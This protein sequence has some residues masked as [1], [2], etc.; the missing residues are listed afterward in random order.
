MPLSS[1]DKMTLDADVISDLGVKKLVNCPYKV[2]VNGEIE[3][4]FYD[5]RD[6]IGYARA[7]KAKRTDSQIWVSD[8]CNGRLIIE[9]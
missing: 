1:I 2:M 3:D 9:I 6:A 8:K 7:V 4:E 5:V